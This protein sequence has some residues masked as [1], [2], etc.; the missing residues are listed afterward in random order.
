MPRGLNNGADS[1]PAFLP[2][3]RIESDRRASWY[4]DQSTLTIMQS[5]QIQAQGLNFRLSRL[6]NRIIFGP[7]PVGWF[8]LLQFG[9]LAVDP[10]KVISNSVYTC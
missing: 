4:S 5:G 9:C 1:H 3:I 6:Y 7:V 8:V 2:C 10:F